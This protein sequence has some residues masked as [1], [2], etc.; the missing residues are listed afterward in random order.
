[1][2]AAAAAAAKILKEDIEGDS[3]ND[4]ESKERTREKLEQRLTA[5]Y[6]DVERLSTTESIGR[7]NVVHRRT[8]TSAALLFLALDA[9]EALRHRGRSMSVADEPPSL[10][11]FHPGS[12]LLGDFVVESGCLYLS[13]WLLP[14]EPLRSK[15]A[16]EI[17]HLSLKHNRAGSSA[18]FV[19]HI[20]IVGSIRCETQREA[21]ELGK[22]LKKKLRGT[23]PVPCRFRRTPC[24]SMYDASN[25]LVWSQS[26]IAIMERSDEY[27]NLLARTREALKLPLGEWIF[28]GPAHEP[29][30]SKYYGS[31]PPLSDGLAATSTPI[32]QPPED[33]VAHEAALFLTTPGTLNG[34]SQWRE[35][36]RIDLRK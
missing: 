1:M 10:L 8:Q 35:V 28:P 16:R 9:P 13:F 5:L 4:G 2:S 11:Q 12:H 22:H 20:T 19:P 29:H 36:T 33:F 27:M 30:F 24:E 26:C 17:A 32:I 23:G 14:P 6:G 31:R 3:S 21:T 18:P 25:T 7:R 15:F 34:V